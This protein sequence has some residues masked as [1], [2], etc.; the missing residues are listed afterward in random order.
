MENN[1]YE[2][3][4]RKPPKVTRF[5]K[6]RSGN[7][8]GRPKQSRNLVVWIDE[9]LDK[10]VVV[11]ENGKKAQ[12]TKREVLAKQIVNGALSGNAKSTSMLISM[13]QHRQEQ[14]PEAI[15]L[16]TTDMEQYQRLRQRLIDSE[17]RSKAKKSGRSRK[18]SGHKTKK[19]RD[20]AQKK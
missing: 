10:V 12:L 14:E 7:P 17:R 19:R 1:Q 4:Y 18:K 13:D 15:Q 2:V 6:G 11:Q 9:E 8:K 16:T 5:K 20:N 3:G